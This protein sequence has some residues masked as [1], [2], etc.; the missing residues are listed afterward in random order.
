MNPFAESWIGAIKRECLDH[1]L[2]LGERHLQYLIHEYL[3]HFHEERPHQG[4]GN[5]PPNQSDL[6]AEVFRF[7]VND[8][9]CRERLGGLLRH[10]EYK[11]A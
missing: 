3:A 7:Q 8:V 10:Y 9:V 5:R 6:P 4:L 2:I 1:F 11:A